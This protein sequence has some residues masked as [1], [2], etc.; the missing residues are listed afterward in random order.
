MIGDKD[1]SI[2]TSDRV[3]SKTL[4]NKVLVRIDL[5][6]DEYK[7]GIIRGDSLWDESGHA[8]RT[9]V[10]CVKPDRLFNKR[11][12]GHGMDWK[13]PY[14]EQTL[15]VG[16][17]VYFGLVESFNCPVI[18][19]D[20]V[21]YFLVDFQ[22]IIF[23]KRGRGER[24]IPLNGYVLVGEYRE[25]EKSKYIIVPDN[26]EKQNLKKGVVKYVGKMNSRYVNRKAKDA[27][28]VNVGDVVNFRMNLWTKLEDERYCTFEKGLGY[29]QRR[30][31]N[32]KI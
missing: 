10:V 15:L 3:P 17:V 25:K 31:I 30:W 8:V 26:T 18:I 29:V 16:D 13:F 14:D 2:V 6:P 1:R 23:V 28:D 27:V 20:G 11:D 19:V 21:R 24:I 4:N 12:H 7:S 32:Y 22:E 5:I 9:G